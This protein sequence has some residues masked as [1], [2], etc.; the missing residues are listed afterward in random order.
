MGWDGWISSDLQVLDKE[1]NK[2]IEVEVEEEAVMDVFNE[3]S[4][5]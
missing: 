5:Q 2:T 1:T 3:G 4:L